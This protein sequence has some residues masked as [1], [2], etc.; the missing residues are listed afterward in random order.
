MMSNL[1]LMLVSAASGALLC[2]FVG[3]LIGAIAGKGTSV[4]LPG[5]GLV[6]SGP[7]ALGFAVGLIGAVLGSMLGF[8]IAAII[9]RSRRGTYR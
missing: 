9:I 4:L 8:F 5:L 1:R 2:G 6:I 3:A 7:L